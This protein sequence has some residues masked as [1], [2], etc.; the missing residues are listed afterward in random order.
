[1]GPEAKLTNLQELVA[2]KPSHID[3][4]LQKVLFMIRRPGGPAWP[5]RLRLKTL[6]DEKL[7]DAAAEVGEAVIGLTE[8]TLPQLKKRNPINRES[9]NGRHLGKDFYHNGLNPPLV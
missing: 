1:M 3:D 5:E 7:P 8:K 4:A 6:S 9:L 2:R